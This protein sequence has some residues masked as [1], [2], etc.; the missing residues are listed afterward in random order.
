MVQ[1]YRTRQIGPSLSQLFIQYSTF[2]NCEHLRLCDPAVP[3]HAPLAS[4]VK[5]VIFQ[6]NQSLLT[7][8]DEWILE[9]CPQDLLVLPL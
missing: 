9:E 3:E 7:G 4:Y 5:S 8:R 6:A 1:N 2:Y